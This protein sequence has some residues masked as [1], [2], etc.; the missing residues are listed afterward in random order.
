M[1]SYML[2]HVTDIRKQRAV[3]VDL[4]SG[5]VFELFYVI[6]GWFSF[7]SYGKRDAFYL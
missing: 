5:D 4:I 6:G 2:L 7:V 1:V 3:T